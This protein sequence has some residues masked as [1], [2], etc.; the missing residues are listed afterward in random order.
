MFHGKK[1]AVFHW[2]FELSNTYSG[3]DKSTLDL[4]KIFVIHLFLSEQLGFT[5]GTFH[6]RVF[7][8]YE[9]R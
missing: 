4:P 3:T 2:F 5:F 9:N 7:L 8:A 6:G 1:V